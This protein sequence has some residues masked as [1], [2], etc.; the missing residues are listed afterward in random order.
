M[1]EVMMSWFFIWYQYNMD[2][3]TLPFHQKRESDEAQTSFARRNV[4]I[5]THTLS[6]LVKEVLFDCS[7]RVTEAKSVF[8][9]SALLRQMYC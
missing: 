2:F 7:Q 1:Q 9:H 8:T 4:V 5:H 6:F 3:D